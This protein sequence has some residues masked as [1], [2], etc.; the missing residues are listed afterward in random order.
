MSE[1]KSVQGSFASVAALT[2]NEN[3]VF[4]N[5]VER[6]EKLSKKDIDRK[7]LW[8]DGLIGFKGEPLSAVVAEVS[9]YTNI[10]IEI[11]DPALKDTPIG[12]F[13][14]IGDIEGLFDALKTV[15]HI[16]VHREDA[17]HVKLTR[18]S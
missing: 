11:E 10:E 6:L 2:V 15:F 14:M 17:H 18:Q 3:A 16:E 13:F 4:D 9:R 8:R 5:K 12:G 1:Q 7:L